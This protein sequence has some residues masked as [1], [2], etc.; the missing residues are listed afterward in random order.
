MSNIYAQ[1][2][3]NI[4]ERSTRDSMS[5]FDS[6]DAFKPK[7]PDADRYQKDKVF[8]ERADVLLMDDNISADYQIISGD[9]QF[10]KEGMFMYCDSAYFYEQKNSLDAF[11]NVRMEQGDTLF[12]YSDVMYYD[13][14]EELARLRGNVRMINKD[15]TLYTD[16]L[17]YDMAV[18]L[19]FYFNGG[20][21]VDVENDLTSIYGQYSP[22]TKDAEFLFDVVLVNE[23]YTMETDTLNY[24]T[25]TQI[26]DI[27][28]YTTIVSDSSVIYSQKGWY[29]TKVDV[30]TLYKRSM[31]VGK[32]NE[33]LTGDTLF[34]DRNKSFGEAFGNMVLS[35]S[36]NKMILKGDYGF[37]DDAKKISFA[38][39]RAMVMEYSQG[40]T[41]YMHGDSIMTFIDKADTSRIM[42][43][44]H[45]VRFFREDMQG[46]ADSIS[47]Q[48][49]DSIMYMYRNPVIWN[50]N[51]QISGNE[52][53]VHM[54]DS[55]MDWVKLPNM[56]IMAEHI[57]ESFYNQLSGKEVLIYF[58]NG[59][60]DQMDV[61]GNVQTL[62]YPTEADS[63]FNKMVKAESSFMLAKFK[64]GAV[65]MMKMWPSVTGKAYPLFMT[66]KS[67]IFLPSFKWHE[68]IRPKD[69]DDIF[70]IPQE[71]V[72]LIKSA[73]SVSASTG[74]NRMT[75]KSEP[76]EEE[77]EELLNDED[78]LQEDKDLPL[79]DDEIS[80]DSSD[81]D[82]VE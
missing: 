73:D 19:G 5:I 26:A 17:D 82:V 42:T 20:R 30:A 53:H 13:G 36:I 41:L 1:E 77:I 55:T 47:Y 66:L 74:R 80:A 43:A 62:V 39:K 46:V 7:V 38:T 8:L 60:I 24:N 72:D 71:M 29:D 37:H 40:D 16:S 67:D 14:M 51:K 57:E 63:T 81:I 35:D 3:V 31:M 6:E 10:R 25:D 44:Y 56:G 34:Y 9:V 76:K 27:V 21:L 79:S 11:G 49:R 48:T 33:K 12:V 75:V 45:K 22:D 69:K 2:P 32:D 64:N 58:K 54:N 68:G 4:Y 15:V 78:E 28:G 65:D 52:M 50:E 59:S 18:N 23:R 61:N 70:N